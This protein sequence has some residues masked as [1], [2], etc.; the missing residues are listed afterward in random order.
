MIASIAVE[1][2]L[3]NKLRPMRSTESET[4]PKL[5][6]RIEACKNVLKIDSDSLPKFVQ[7]MVKLLFLCGSDEW[8]QHT[9]TEIG[10]PKPSAHQL[11]QPFLSNFLFPF[12]NEFLHVYIL[13]RT[14]YQYES[15]NQLLECL[16]YIECNKNDCR[17]NDALVKQRIFYERKIAGNFF[18]LLLLLNGKFTINSF[19][20]I[21]QNAK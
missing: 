15:A 18:Y 1:I 7:H 14:L 16:T 12:P 20:F 19:Q 11:L 21:F 3:A 5:N 10:L 4:L 17:N 9:I 13:F 8:D 6:D 2:F